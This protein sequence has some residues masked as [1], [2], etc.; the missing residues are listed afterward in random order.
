MQATGK[1]LIFLILSLIIGLSQN[2]CLAVTMDYIL[3]QYS[4][5]LDLHSYI[6]NQGLDSFSEKE[7]A[8]LDL[9]GQ[10]RSTFQGDGVS[11]QNLIYKNLETLKQIQNDLCKRLIMPK[12]LRGACS[13][14]PELLVYVDTFL[15]QAAD[16][17]TLEEEQNLEQKLFIIDEILYLLKDTGINLIFSG[18]RKSG[19]KLI[20]SLYSQS[21]ECLG[22]IQTN[23]FR[24]FLFS[25]LKAINFPTELGGEIDAHTIP[26]KTT[27]ELMQLYKDFL[28]THHFQ[29]QNS[30]MGKYFQE[31]DSVCPICQENLL[32]KCDTF[33]WIKKCGHVFHTSCFKRNEARGGSTCPIC[34]V[35]FVP[36]TALDNP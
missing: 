25:E 36:A 29:D 22:E 13:G 6:I 11:L 20:D 19:L 34:R 33:T 1:K 30:Q 23:I 14:N 2:N 32:S 10:I 9:I 26:S 16:T 7:L 3:S 15:R 24:N 8:Q 18:I 4:Q 31:E 21:I 17:C 27:G 12:R 28:L 5:D 35:S